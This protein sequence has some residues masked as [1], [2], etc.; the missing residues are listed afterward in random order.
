MNTSHHEVLCLRERVLLGLILP[1]HEVTAL[2]HRIS[3]A[4]ET[5]N[6]GDVIRAILALRRLRA[7]EGYDG[8]A[9]ASVRRRMDAICH[10][11]RMLDGAP[12]DRWASV[13]AAIATDLF[14]RRS[15]QPDAR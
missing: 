8:E 1:P 3:A 12:E 4:M 15:R 2:L 13:E 5:R 9:L 10:S 14:A 11:I 6:P 7:A